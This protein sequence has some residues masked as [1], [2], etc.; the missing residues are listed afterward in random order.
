MENIKTKEKTQHSSLT[1]KFKKKRKEKDL[2]FFQC[3][4]TKQNKKHAGGPGK[5]RIK[6]FGT[7]KSSGF[8]RKGGKRNSFS[9]PTPLFWPPSLAAGS[10]TT[11][12][13]RKLSPLK[14]KGWEGGGSLSQGPG[15]TGPRWGPGAPSLPAG[16]SIS[17]LGTVSLSVIL[18]TVAGRGH[19][20]PPSPPKLPSPGRR[21]LRIRLGLVRTGV[22]FEL[23]EGGEGP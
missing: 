6:S 11:L 20:S 16:Y 17:A 21:E 8:E 13:S 18:F 19:P 10:G 12:W 7:W 4:K 2:F 22:I 1:Q 9:F 23:G 5:R 3:F 15:C 14:P